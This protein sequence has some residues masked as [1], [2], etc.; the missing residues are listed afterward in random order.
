M[1]IAINGFGRIGRQVFRAWLERGGGS[2]GTE[3]DSIVAINDPAD[4]ELLVH[5]LTY[6]SVHGRLAEPVRYQDG[7]LE[8]RGRR[9][10]MSAEREPE[11]CPWG[12][13]DVDVVLECS[14]R[15]TRRSDAQRH[16]QASAKRVLISAPA[17]EDVDATIVY[18]VNHDQLKPEHTVVSNASCTTNALAPLLAP[19][20][21][22]FGIVSGLMTTV[23][24]YT[25]DQLLHD[26][27]HKDPHRARAAAL[28]MIP[29][30]TGAAAA[31]GAVIPELA[32]RLDGLAVRV[33]TANVSLVDVTLEMA[34]PVALEA[35][36]DVLIQASKEEL[37]DVLMTN[38]LPLVSV[39]FNH[40]S[41]SSVVDLS[42]T[43]VQGRMVK[44]L[45]WY[46]NEWG[47]ANRLLDVV[48]VW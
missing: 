25:S 12:D 40:C 44:L 43:R 9:I 47:F 13:C 42:Q 21:R 20:Q 41:A 18:G 35:I 37:K 4:P 28:S 24:A 29:T 2:Q 36:H 31:I 39:D 22:A 19:L 30:K 17:G 5:L 46:D 38:A 45:A 23:H 15:W 26:A 48:A 7:A 16:L 6:D 3:T 11:A 34:D 14:G 32:G 8:V 1:N 10:P 27:P 33:P